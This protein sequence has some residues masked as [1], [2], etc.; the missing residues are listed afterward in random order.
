MEP[1]CDAVR[2]DFGWHG[3]QELEARGR[4]TI[5]QTKLGRRPRQASEKQGFR[6]RVRHA[7]Q[8]GSKSVVESETTS[9]AAFA[10]YRNTS[11]AELIDVTIDRPDGNLEMLRQFSRGHPAARLQHE[12]DGQETAGQQISKPKTN[13]T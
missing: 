11:R 13:L 8:L 6:L 10:I 3:R 12:L 7:G 1:G 4:E 2:L 5:G 9:P